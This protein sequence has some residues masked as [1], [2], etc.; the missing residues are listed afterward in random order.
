MVETLQSEATE[1][2]VYSVPLEALL[3][4]HQENLAHKPVGLSVVPTSQSSPN[5]SA[6][7]F[8]IASLTHRVVRNSCILRCSSSADSTPFHQITVVIHIPNATVGMDNATTG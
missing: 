3:A 4:E 8:E 6:H 2:A 5:N 1:A 7:D